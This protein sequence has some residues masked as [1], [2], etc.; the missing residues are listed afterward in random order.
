[1]I[2]SHC[3]EVDAGKGL[4]IHCLQDHM[5]D[6]AFPRECRMAVTDDL[7]AS[8]HDWRLK[9]GLKNHCEKDATNLCN[10]ELLEGG[11]KLISCLTNKLKEIQSEACSVEMK[12]Y[13][14]QG[15]DN[16]KLAPYTYS[17]SVDDVHYLCPDVVPGSGRV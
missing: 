2:K 14:K 9:Y 1:M 6:S 3:N 4:V 15:L 13:V 5:K 8:N 17:K 11:A 10:E 16:I 7:Q 12:T